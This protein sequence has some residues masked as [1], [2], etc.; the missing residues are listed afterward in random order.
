MQIMC[1]RMQRIIGHLSVTEMWPV[2]MIIIRIGVMKTVIVMKNVEGMKAEVNQCPL[3]LNFGHLA[4][5]CPL[6]RGSGEPIA[7]VPPVAPV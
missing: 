7:A 1:H 2:Q 5:A 4:K 3:C 6:S